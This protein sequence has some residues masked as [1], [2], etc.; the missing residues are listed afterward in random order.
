MG[1]VERLRR[2]RAVRRHLERRRETLYRLAY[3]WCDDPF[4]A[5]DLVQ[6]AA[7]KAL[8]NAGQLRCVEQV[9]H[10]MVRI[11]SNCWRDHLRRSGRETGGEA[12]RA[13]AESASPEGECE[14]EATVRRVRAALG[15]LTPDQRQV[16]TL[17]DLEGYSYAEAAEV[18]GVPIGTVMSRLC[19]GRRLLRQALLQEETRDEDAIG[20][21]GRRRSRVAVVR[22][23]R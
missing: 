10:W 2:I 17:V 5:D 14:R 8:Q 1:P 3:A 22:R 12:A 6:Q 21:T 18:L 13:W 15:R 4:L 16:V 23:I 11:L 9:G 7:A 19:R 20:D